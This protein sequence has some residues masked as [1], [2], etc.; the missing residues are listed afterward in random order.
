MSILEGSLGLSGLGTKSE[1]AKLSSFGDVEDLTA[2]Q[3]I[4]RMIGKKV[5]KRCRGLV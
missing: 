5:S 4:K 1:K 3:K 2:R